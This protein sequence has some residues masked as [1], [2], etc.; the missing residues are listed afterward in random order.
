ML[1]IGCSDSLKSQGDDLAVR[2]DEHLRNTGELPESLKELGIVENE[3]GPIYY[4][5][6]SK[7]RYILWYGLSLGESKVCNSETKQWK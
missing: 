2:L 6:E 3:P 5:K 4:Q 7:N 1:L